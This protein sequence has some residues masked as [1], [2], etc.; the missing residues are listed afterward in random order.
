[1]FDAASVTE[2]F[3][4]IRTPDDNEHLSI[5]NVTFDPNVATTTRGNACMK[6]VRL[7]DKKIPVKFPSA[8]M[9]IPYPP[10]NKL[11]I[12]TSSRRTRTLRTD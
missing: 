1:M 9:P 3:N 11:V 8:E 5:T 4:P 10:S 2:W 7:K 12:L 6:M